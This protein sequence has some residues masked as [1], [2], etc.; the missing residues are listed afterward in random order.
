MFVVEGMDEIREQ[1]RRL[2]NAGIA[3]D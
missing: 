3:N 1:A 2:P